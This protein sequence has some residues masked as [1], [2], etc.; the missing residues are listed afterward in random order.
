MAC[1]KKKVNKKTFSILKLTR[2]LTL[3]LYIIHSSYLVN[4]TDKFVL[5]TL[6]NWLRTLTQSENR[7]LSAGEHVRLETDPASSFR[8]Q[9]WDVSWWDNDGKKFHW[10]H[11][12]SD[13]LLQKPVS[14]EWETLATAVASK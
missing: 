4:N 13:N 11:H 2:L 8:F 9:C 7:F 14:S 6:V 3:T 10:V 5:Y 12:L 1:Y